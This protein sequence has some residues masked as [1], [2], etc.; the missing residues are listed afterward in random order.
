MVGLVY[1][2]DRGQEKMKEL[3]Y[4]N[5]WVDEYVES[6]ELTRA[7]AGFTDLAKALGA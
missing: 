7:M 1:K 4:D 5:V 6:T 2:G 3:A